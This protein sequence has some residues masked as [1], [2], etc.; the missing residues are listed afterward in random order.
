MSKLT[1]RSRIYLKKIKA[2]YGQ[3]VD[4]SNINIDPN[5]VLQPNYQSAYNKVLGSNEQSFSI[6]PSEN[7]AQE[8]PGLDK[9]EMLSPALKIGM[10]I[11][12][13]VES[14]RDRRYQKFHEKEY[15]KDLMERKNQMKS[16]SFYMTPYVAG[17]TSDLT[18]KQGGQVYQQGG[19]T[20]MDAFMNFYNQ[21]EQSKKQVL[22]TLEE[23]YSDKNEALEAKWRDDR[24]N[25][26]KSIGE[27]ATFAIDAAKQAAGMMMQE[28]GELEGIPESEDLYSENFVSPYKVKEQV[29]NELKTESPGENMQGNS[30]LMSW[31]FEEEPLQTYTVSDIYDAKYSK[32]ADSSNSNIPVKPLV[33]QFSSLGINVGSIN[34]GTHNPGSK[35]YSGRAFDIPGS[36]NG[37]KEGLYKIY[38]Y[39]NSPEGKRQFPNIKVL[40]EIEKP[41]G[42]VGDANHLHIE[43]LD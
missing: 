7:Q 23:G 10:G 15:E 3:F 43:L 31:L 22:Q 11:K 16:N 5:A 19:T 34:T 41:A 2:Q 18:M 9:L 13:L 40:N 28:G 6:Q 21:Q 24:A 30:T 20:P 37:G 12:G 8:N 38:N 14:G 4:D 36:K 27:G 1:N 29:E 39:L 26:W 25:S 35:H 42:K 33:D 17:K 32:P